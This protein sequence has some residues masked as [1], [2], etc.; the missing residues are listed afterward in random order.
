MD[1]ID[2]EK[3]TTIVRQVLEE[4]RISASSGVERA[5]PKGE[6]DGPKVL[7]I[8]HAGVSRLDEAM[9]Q[10]RLI[11]GS[12]GKSSVFTDE[13][14][15]CWVCGDDVRKQAGARCILDTVK[16]EG[17][18]KVMERSD[19]LVLPTFCLKVGAKVANLLCDDDGSA[20]VC[21]ALARG[22]KVLA[23]RDGFLLSETLSNIRIREE[24]NRIL[25]KLEA[26]GII[27]SSTDQL[28]ATFQG[29]LQTRKTGQQPEEKAQAGG[30]EPGK[31][32]VT[33]K[34]VSSAAN[35]KKRSVYVTKTGIVT[36]LARDMAKEF[37]IAIVQKH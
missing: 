26:F 2:A 24:M 30:T 16:P 1:V 10:V 6:N 23:S 11:Q 18:Q 29:L 32:I 21:S 31:R 7:I 28:S 34:D 36:P 8:F 17:L 12:A 14:A 35:E 15:R 22:K 5:G 13:S 20:I 37:G 4:M 25:Q 3:V 19:V 33:A 27:F 9:H